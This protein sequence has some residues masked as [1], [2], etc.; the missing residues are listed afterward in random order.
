M[1]TADELFDSLG[2][3]KKQYGNRNIFYYQKNGAKEKFGFEFIFDKYWKNKGE[4]YPVCY[5]KEK[6][7]AINIT[8]QEL[9]AINKKV[10][11]LRVDKIIR[12]VFLKKD[13]KLNQYP[14]NVYLQNALR[15]IVNK[16]Y[17]TAYSEICWAIIKSGGKLTEEQEKIFKDINR[18][19]FK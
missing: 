18:R 15:F 17:N 14:C 2:Y 9:Q 11:E 13:N 8:M 4:I 7:E 1:K 6:E 5:S 19:Y 16:E 12:K 10:E 3:S